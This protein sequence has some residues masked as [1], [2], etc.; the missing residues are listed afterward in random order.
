MEKT[1][2]ALGIPPKFHATRSTAFLRDVDRC[3]FDKLEWTEHIC[4]ISTEKTDINVANNLDQD[5]AHSLCRLAS[6]SKVG[7]GN[8]TVEDEEVRRSKE[9]LADQIQLNPAFRAALEKEGAEM[10]RKKLYSSATPIFHFYKMVVYEEGDHFTW[11]IDSNHRPNMFATM[12]VQIHIQGD[13]RG[14]DLVL[15]TID[16]VLQ[17]CCDY[18]SGQNIHIYEEDDFEVLLD[19]VTRAITIEPPNEDEVTI[20]V[21][22]HDT[23]HKVTEQETGYR[24][25]LI[26]DITH[27]P[28][29]K[30]SPPTNESL[31]YELGII[32]EM[33]AKRVGFICNH[34][35]MGEEL[36]P[37]LLKGSDRRGYELLRQYCE[38]VEIVEL[39]N[40]G[41]ELCRAELM[42]LFTHLDMAVWSSIGWDDIDELIC[43]TR[44]DDGDIDLIR[45][46]D[47]ILREKPFELKEYS[48]AYDKFGSFAA[49]ND[50]YRLGDIYFFDSIGPARLIYK[51]DSE[52]HLGNEGFYGTIYS[53]VAIIA[54]LK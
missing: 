27:D 8:E 5:I 51:G 23:P 43:H 48:P 31:Y 47:P 26:F 3:T 18:E 52:I 42:P 20:A 32:K 40:I 36:I 10:L 16:D 13:N 22:Y 1:K 2:Y 9:I 11:H 50:E 54:I 44:C 39:V 7:K 37:S 41:N 4:T 34:V 15:S 45:I 6:K 17:D 30:L 53:H 21:F 12:S 35:Y 28:E 33:G 46:K 49:I 14:G 24:I 38:K 19:N 25:S 29:E